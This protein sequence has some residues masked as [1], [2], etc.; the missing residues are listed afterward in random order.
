MKCWFYFIVIAFFSIDAQAKVTVLTAPRPATECAAEYSPI[1]DRYE[2]GLIFKVEDCKGTPPSYIMGTMH[3]DDPAFKPIIGN[4]SRLIASS[5]SAGFEF[6]EDKRS[7]AVALQ[8][9]LLLPADPNGLDT[10]LEATDFNKLIQVIGSRT[11]IPAN[12]IGRLRPWAAAL[13]LQY[14]MPKSDGVPLDT[15]LQKYARLKKKEL[16]GLET[17][18]EQYDV[19]ASIRQ[20]KQLVMLKDTL[21]ELDTIDQSN[22]ELAEYY[23]ARDLKKIQHLA[24]DSFVEMKDSELRQHME[25]KLIRQRNQK[26]AERLIPRFSEGNT[27]VAIGA[28]H[29]LG[30]EGVLKLLEKQG[31]R[32]STINE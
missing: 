7:E 6:V 14:P 29:L 32:I 13:L 24:E 26:M 4:A 2:T 31:Y 23:L 20:E 25:E 16:Y 19:F 15:L 17:P 10:L 8:Y 11:K 1:E 28:L 3:H 27:F 21:D 30:E 18:E 12:V 5:D 9:M 22:K